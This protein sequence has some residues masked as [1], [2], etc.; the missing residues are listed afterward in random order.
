[1]ENFVVA[2]KRFESEWSLFGDILHVS[3]NYV[4]I[5]NFSVEYLCRFTHVQVT[6]HLDTVAFLCNDAEHTYILT[7]C[8][9]PISNLSNDLTLQT[10]FPVVFSCLI[11]NV[12]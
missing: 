5:C 1:M 7:Q 4:R 10:Y 8:N 12:P 3:C 9:H 2:F 11:I 6:D